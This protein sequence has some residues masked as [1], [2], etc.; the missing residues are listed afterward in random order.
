MRTPLTM[1]VLA[2]GDEKSLGEVLGAPMKSVP[3][4]VTVIVLKN[5]GY[6]ILEKNTRETTAL[7][8]FL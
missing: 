8:K 7:M 1:P 5:T 4:K 2:I 6:W 3:R